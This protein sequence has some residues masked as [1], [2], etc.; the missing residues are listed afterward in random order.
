MVVECGVRRESRG[1]ALEVAA[2]SRLSTAR[3]HSLHIGGKY[4]YLIHT[5]R[6]YPGRI[7]NKRILERNVLVE[8]SAPLVCIPQSTRTC[9]AHCNGLFSVLLP[10]NDPNESKIPHRQKQKN[11]PFCGGNPFLAPGPS[12][13]PPVLRA[14]NSPPQAS[15]P[16]LMRPLFID[17][18]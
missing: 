2:V 10:T 9:G 15:H 17:T 12:P 4:I 7:P 1:K 6:S 16:H 13:S 8:N 11:I 14:E 3:A 18:T 5:R